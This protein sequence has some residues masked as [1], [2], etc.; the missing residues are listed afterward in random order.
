[1]AAPTELQEIS[2]SLRNLFTLL[3]KGPEAEA[4]EVA[5]AA[6]K[7]PLNAKEVRSISLHNLHTGEKSSVDYW[8]DGQYEKDALAE[9]NKVLR[10]HRTDK[11]CEIDKSLI[12]YLSSVQKKL[13]VEGKT[14]EVISGYRAPE[15]NAKLRQKSRGVAK[16]S[17]HMKGMAVD[18]QIPGRSSG[19]VYKAA[20]DLKLGGAGYYGKSRFVHL[21]VGGVRSWRG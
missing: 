10:D 3:I 6:A 5:K 12:D 11:V 20:T 14:F 9:I 4:A 16:E 19:L 17:F 18:I 13:D 7:T 2:S 15:S 21:D 8:F 1:M